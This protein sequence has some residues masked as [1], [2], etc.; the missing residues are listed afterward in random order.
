MSAIDK[1]FAGS[2]PEIYERH[3]VPLIFEPYAEDLAG[4]LCSRR[5]SRVLEL[6]AGTGVVTRAL[7]RELP[8][9]CEIVATDLNQAML[10]QAAALGTAHPF[11]WRQADASFDADRRR[12]IGVRSEFQDERANDPPVLYC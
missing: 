5:V 8:R 3:L 6:A 2:I 10:D 9:D 4:R 1:V 7:A 12:L 11:E